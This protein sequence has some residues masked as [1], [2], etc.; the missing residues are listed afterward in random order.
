MEAQMDVAKQR[1]CVGSSGFPLT[2]RGRGNR[3]R[4]DG[5]YD[6]VTLALNSVKHSV[7]RC[8]TRGNGTHAV[9]K[10]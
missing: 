4:N 1:L 5:M 6:F 3:T 8:I 9:S 10:K 7:L 2:W